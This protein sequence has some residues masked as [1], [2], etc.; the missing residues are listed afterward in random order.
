[1]KSVEQGWYSIGEVADQLGLH[2]RTV[3]NYVRDGKLKAVRIGKQYR[4][5]REDFEALTGRT[6]EVE[7]SPAAS[8]GRL[9]VSSIV[10]IDQ[11]DPDA[12]Y[13]L[14]TLVTA[15]VGSGRDAADPLRVQTVYEQER[16]RMKIVVLGGAAD[17]AELL[18]LIDSVVGPDTGLFTT[19]ENG[20]GADRG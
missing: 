9:E 5:S 8:P 18:R 6:S 4:I 19:P 17:T 2:V 16:A 12:A 10:Q 1:M 11:V 3:R 7:P 13:R 14:S 15:S 20:R